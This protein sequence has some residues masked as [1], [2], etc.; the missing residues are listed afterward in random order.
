[1]KRLTIAGLQIYF[2]DQG[3][4]HFDPPWK[5]RTA[6]EQELE[7][8][9]EL[10]DPWLQ[11]SHEPQPRKIGPKE[12]RMRVRFKA[13]VRGIH[14]LG[15]DREFIE[16]TLRAAAKRA[17]PAVAHEHAEESIAEAMSTL[18]R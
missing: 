7:S 9:Q 3:T 8:H 13:A 2:D 17:Y 15:F 5:Q 1:M 4:A 14:K 18:D 10:I 12:Q 6:V 16:E 11:A